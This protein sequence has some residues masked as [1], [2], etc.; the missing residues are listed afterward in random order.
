MQ[1]ISSK[2]ANGFF[3][4]GV[5]KSDEPNQQMTTLKNEFYVVSMIDVIN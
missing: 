2:T 3:S 4:G 5:S 1:M